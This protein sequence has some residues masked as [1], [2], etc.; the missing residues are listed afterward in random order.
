MACKVGRPLVEQLRGA[1]IP[2]LVASR[3]GQ[4]PA[5]AGAEL[6]GVK[7]D[8]DDEATWGPVLATPIRAV[9][10]ITTELTNQETVKKFVT[11]AREK[12]GISR[13]VLLSA[14]AVPEGGPLT[15]QTHKFLRELGDEGKIG[16]AVL[17]P[18]WFQENFLGGHHTSS[19][20]DEN[21]LY[22]ASGSGRIPWVST[23]DI[24]AVG[25][26][27]LTAAEPPN[28][29]YIVLGPEL[30]VYAELAEIFTSV[31]GRKI[32]YQEIDEATL[33][34][35]YE[36]NGVPAEFAKLVASMDTMIK[37]GAEDRINDVVESVTGRKPRSFREF[38]EANKAVWS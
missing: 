34:A 2:T 35:V 29:E 17:R 10:I 36:K 28:K 23:S 22:S 8:W 30:L 20:I 26:H 24:A 11:Q 12:A 21:K 25:L 33:A 31:L 1:N 32:T 14:S 13:F 16:W 5:G 18:T 15:G 9:F 38:V 7:F 4:A 37:N 27:A 19:L 3:S 6:T